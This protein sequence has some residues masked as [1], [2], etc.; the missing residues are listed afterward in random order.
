MNY[1]MQKNYFLTSSTKRIL[2]VVKVN[3]KEISDGK[4]GGFT[5]IIFK[6]F[7]ELENSFSIAD[8]Q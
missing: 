4:P 8:N 1:L 2:P 7:I 5:E 6:K 3:D